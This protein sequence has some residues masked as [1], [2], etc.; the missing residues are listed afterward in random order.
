MKVKEDSI[1][2]VEYEGKLKNGETFD[3]S[4]HENHFKIKILGV[5]Q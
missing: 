2:V 3:F 1:V 5:N 4:K